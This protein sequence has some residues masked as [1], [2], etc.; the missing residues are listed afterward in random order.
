MRTFFKS[1][2]FKIILGVLAALLLG[3]FIAAVSAGGSTPL[4]QALNFV[5][6]P[7]NSA[8]RHLSDALS[9]FRGGFVSSAYYQTEIE[10]LHSEIESYKQ[11]LVDHEQLKQKLAAY[12][13][14]LDVK[15]AHPDYH[16]QPATI[17]LRDGMD[18]YSA[19]TI[20]RGTADGVQVDMPVIFGANLIGVVREVTGHSAVVYTLFHPDVSVS[21]YEIRTR[22]DCYTEADNAS[23]L[24]GQI[25]LMGLS[26]TSPMAAGGIVCTSGIGGI[27]PRDL[28]IGTVAEVTGSE[29]NISAYGLVEPSVDLESLVDVFVITNYGENAG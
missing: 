23:S 25:K 4:T 21:A 5:M 29:E 16:F 8:A 20:D 14:F 15:S 26:R 27:F 1:L 24:E 6:Q 11:E 13:Q 7:L 18:I 9:E 2:K 19:F 12:E 3:V 28:V 10:S 17:I 22:E